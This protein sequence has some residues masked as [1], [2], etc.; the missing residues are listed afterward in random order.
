[1]INILL[2]FVCLGLCP[3]LQPTDI[4]RGP[5]SPASFLYREWCFINASADLRRPVTAS[6]ASAT[7]AYDRCSSHNPRTTGKSSRVKFSDCARGTGPEILVTDWL[8]L[9]PRDS[10]MLILNLDTGRI[11]ILEIRSRLISNLGHRAY[12]GSGGLSLHLPLLSGASVAPKSSRFLHS[13]VIVDPKSRTS[14]VV[15]L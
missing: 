6:D 2:H 1:M 8:Y 3:P 4:S 13:V 9:Y 12:L 11:S 5:V 14:V 7:F 10:F 15:S